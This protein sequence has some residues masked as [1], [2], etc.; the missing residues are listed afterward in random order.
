MAL[1]V[2]IVNHTSGSISDEDAQT[3]I[4]AINRQIAGDFAPAWG[5]TGELRLEGRGGRQPRQQQPTEMR[6][7]AVIYLWDKVDVDDALGYHDRNHRGVPF[8]FVFT[9]LSQEL[10][11]SWSVTLSH[12]V[13][14]LLGDPQVNLLVAGPHP[15]EPE[16]DVFFWFEMADAVQAESYLIDGVEV[17]NFLLPL[18]FTGEDETAGR[19]DFL[20]RLYRG[21]PLGSFGVNPGGYIGFFDPVTGQD[22]THSLRGDEKAAKRLAVKER[23]GKTRRVVRYKRFQTSRHKQTA[24]TSAKR[25][26]GD[27]P[28]LAAISEE[29]GC[30][31][32]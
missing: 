21:K 15:T 26:R 32:A 12:E 27:R 13:L 11:E 20:G 22:E 14:E 1:R 23:A 19:N 10:G 7:D 3:V 2:S 30:T 17:S 6:G 5:M 4:R 18:Y 25:S 29:D 16:R 24:G 28:E 8:G 31:G 9:E